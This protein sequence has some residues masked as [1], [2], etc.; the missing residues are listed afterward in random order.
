M[1]QQ[2]KKKLYVKN[3]YGYE[4]QNPSAVLDDSEIEFLKSKFNIKTD[5][6]HRMCINCQ[7]RQLIKYSEYTNDNKFKVKCNF[8]PKGLGRGSVDRLNQLMTENDIDKAQA[9]R[10][11]KASVDPVAW[12]ELMFGFR[13]E[14]PTWHLRSYQKEQ[15]RCT[16]QRMVLREGRR[17]GKTM[18]MALKLLYEA[19]N[20]TIEKGADSLGKRLYTGP[21]IM[22]ITP[23]QSQL[24]NM[25]NEMESLLKRNAAL[26]SMCTTG[27]AGSL[28]IKT[29][30]YRMQI[31]RGEGMGQTKIYGFV[32]GIGTRD[33]GAGGGTVRGGSA[34]IIY[35]DEMDMI[36][37]DILERVIQPILLT[38]PG[39]RLFATSTPIG[40]RGK[41]YSYCKERPDFKEDYLP[42]SV[43]P[44][45]ENIKEEFERDSTE[46]SFAAEYMAEFVEG[47]FGVFK[48]SLVYA[49]RADYTYRNCEDVSWWHNYAK[50]P[51][52]HEL[53]KVIGID[54]NKNAGSE[55][56]T[57]A[58]DP[59]RHFW[60]VVD[61]TNIGAGEFSSIKWKQ[62]VIRLNYKWR[63]DYIYADEGYGHHIIE[64][65]KLYAHNLKIKKH[66]TREEIESAKLSERLVAFNFSQTIELSNPIDGSPITKRGKEFL[67]ENTIRVFEDQRIWF[68]EEDTILLKQLINY[69]IL[70][71]SKINNRPVYGA[72]NESI[73]D[74]RLDAFMLALAGLHLEGS[75]YS[76][77][78]APISLPSMHR[79]EELQKPTPSK[80]SAAIKLIDHFRKAS[81]GFAPNVLEIER[82]E[83]SLI[84][85][86]YNKR[87]SKKRSRGDIFESP[88]SVLEV[89]RR[90]A[91]DYRGY[92]ND[93]E[94][95]YQSNQLSAPQIIKRK[96]RRRGRF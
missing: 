41:F 66:K 47:R 42:S 82:S 1:L 49:A 79:K 74:H 11:I 80:E 12:A 8:V 29:P 15:I 87:D 3:E 43:L 90:R 70:R 88:N 57:V 81:G 35:L 7:A 21:E 75:V 10:I 45:W 33:D 9:L 76:R 96:T 38:R 73:G 61:A 2:I 59:R 63:P 46:E 5:S 17:S 28:Y 44:N 86:Y 92:S 31:E 19:F 62:E 6:V 13:D 22:I 37:E 52:T 36:P 55:F 56:V 24:T 40:K 67:V 94:H 16:A 78:N 84:Q 58:Y 14:D 26:A 60:I 64:D 93:T 34:D 72:S 69:T 71:R 25:F 4:Y 53:I 91:K 23:Y 50:V 32:S 39:V 18:A 89:M 95:L 77:K 83:Q 27:S 20:T 54:W 85:E 51:D 68:P 48:P 65:L 30:F